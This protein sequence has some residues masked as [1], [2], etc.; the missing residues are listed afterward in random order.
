VEGD[1]SRMNS[2]DDVLH[3]CRLSILTQRLT[4]AC[5][6]KFVG[7]LSIGGALFGDHRLALLVGD[8]ALLALPVAS[9]VSTSC[10]DVFVVVPLSPLRWGV[11]CCCFFISWICHKFASVLGL[12]YWF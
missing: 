4:I 11:C 6:M 7:V 1:W 2:I 3:G 8:V 9:G 5:G 12:L 10:S